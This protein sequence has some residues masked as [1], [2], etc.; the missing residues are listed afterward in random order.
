MSN[1]TEADVLRINAQRGKRQ[2]QTAAI[3]HPPA[4]QQKFRA[5]PCIVTADLTLFTRE[6][7]QR[8]EEANHL[9]GGGTLKEQAARQGIHGEHFDSTKE[10]NRYIEL[11]RMETAGA[12]DSLE[13]HP[14]FELYVVAEAPIV[15]QVSVGR[16]TADFAYWT[17]AAL[18]VESRRVIEDVKSPITR[19]QMDYRLRK[20][21]F[22]AIYGLTVTEV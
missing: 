12:I 22:E 1:W 21:I 10:G 3:Q 9:H 20:R 5:V 19:T 2:Q 6:D 17:Q 13:I 14:R 15:Q 4:K 18:G 11:K 7:I 8:L 16:F